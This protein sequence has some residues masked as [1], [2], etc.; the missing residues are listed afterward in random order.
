M[1]LVRLPSLGVFSSC[2]KITNPWDF[3]FSRVEVAMG[4]SGGQESYPGREQGKAVLQGIYVL[5]KVIQSLLLQR[6]DGRHRKSPPHYLRIEG[7][8]SFMRKREWYSLGCRRERG[9]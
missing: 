8:G 5:V 1:Y 7:N 2:L 9:A 6:D 3:P 4:R